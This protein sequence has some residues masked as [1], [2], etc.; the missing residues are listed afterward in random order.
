MHLKFCSEHFK[1]RLGAMMDDLCC[2]TILV[3]KI[4]YQLQLCY[5]SHIYICLRSTQAQNSVVPV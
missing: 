1:T 2:T 3:V 5:H 4:P